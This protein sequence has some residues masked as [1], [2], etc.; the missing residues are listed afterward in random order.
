MHTALIEDM[1]AFGKDYDADIEAV[2][3]AITL[4][5]ARQY[6]LPTAPPKA[7][8]PRRGFTDSETVQC[9]ALDPRTLAAIVQAAI[10]ERIQREI[11]EAVLAEEEEARRAVLARLRR[12]P[13]RR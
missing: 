7:T 6:R 10:D 2:R 4:E 12:M 11:Y 9:E 1:I 3:V 8:D 5:Q 13:R